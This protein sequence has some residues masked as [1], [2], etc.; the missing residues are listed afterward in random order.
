LL[1][2][3]P[4]QQ[5]LPP[6]L[7]ARVLAQHAAVLRRCEVVHQRDVA[8]VGEADAVAAAAAGE[9]AVPAGRRRRQ[10]RLVHLQHRPQLLHALVHD[11]LVAHQADVLVDEAVPHDGLH[12]GLVLVG[13]HLQPHVHH[14]RLLHAAAFAE[15][16]ELRLVLAENVPSDRQL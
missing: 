7:H 12:G 1:H 9:V 15:P 11:A 14:C 10:P 5:R 2:R 4:R 8:E 16:Q 6:R 13:L 3:R